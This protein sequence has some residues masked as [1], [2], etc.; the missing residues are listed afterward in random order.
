[1]FI[2]M[3]EK[4]KTCLVFLYLPK[5]PFQRRMPFHLEK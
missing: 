1:M 4:L 2:Y 3:R 5:K